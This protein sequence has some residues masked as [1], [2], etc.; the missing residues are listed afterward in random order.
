[1]C[2]INFDNIVKVSTT[3][4]VRDL[5]KIAKPTNMMCKECV[6]AKQKRRSFSSKTFTTKIFKI[7][8][9]R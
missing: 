2:H 9:Y 1:M 7:L 6:L 8:N 4:A 3:F 5:L